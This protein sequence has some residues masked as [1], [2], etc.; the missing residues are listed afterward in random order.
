MA[1][2]IDDGPRPK[3]AQLSD[4]LAD[5]ALREL[6]PDT[7]IPSERELMATYDVSRDTVRKAINSLVAGGL[8]HRIQGMMES[9]E[10]K[11]EQA[12]EAQVRAEEAQVRERAA[13]RALA[14]LTVLRVRG[15]AVPDAE[16]DRILAELSEGRLER[17]LEKA[18]TAGS[19]AEVLAEPSQE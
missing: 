16:R 18:I 17:W 13:T 15:L 1:R 11:A 3:H 6:G 4:A 2:R 10:S 14:V 5:L 19:L 12:E 8:L 7:A 9:L